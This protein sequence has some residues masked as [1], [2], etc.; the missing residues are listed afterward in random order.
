[1]SY[2]VL[3]NAQENYYRIKSKI[4]NDPLYTVEMNRNNNVKAIAVITGATNGIGKE[5][6]KKLMLQNFDVFLPCRD[7]IKGLQVASEIGIHTS[8]VIYLDLSKKP[9]IDLFVFRL[10]QILESEMV[11][12]ILNVLINNAACISEDLKLM[13]NTNH[14]GPLYLTKLLL[15][16]LDRSFDGRVINVSSVAHS[17]AKPDMENIHN[18]SG[19]NAMTVYGNTKLYNLLMTAYI[20]KHSNFVVSTAVHPGYVNSDLYRSNELK[21]ILAR[22]KD[23]SSIFGKTVEEGAR[24]VLYP[25][26]MPIPYKGYMANFL[27][28][29]VCEFDNIDLNILS[30]ILWEN[31]IYKV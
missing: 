7:I 3:K 11:T 19:V 13:Y 16:M 8:R 2:F 29:R 21:G 22:I 31:G 17:M 25:T 20:N 1:M 26:L 10:K 12:P 9:S 14:E 18:I 30:D 15:P 6:A 27:P 23:G 24:Q 4:F 28:E 5:V